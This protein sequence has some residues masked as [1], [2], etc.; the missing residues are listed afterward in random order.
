MLFS[1]TEADKQ[2]YDVTPCL[3]GTC[4]N[5]MRLSALERLCL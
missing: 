5:R 3:H 1:L 4:R 2:T